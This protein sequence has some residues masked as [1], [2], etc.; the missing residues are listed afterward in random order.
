MAHITNSLRMR[1]LQP[2]TNLATNKVAP[3][4][5]CAVPSGSVAQLYLNSTHASYECS[6][7]EDV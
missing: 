6:S 2:S 3:I 1:G 5:D 7:S 4:G